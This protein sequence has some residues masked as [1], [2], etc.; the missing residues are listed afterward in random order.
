MTEAAFE[1][2]CMLKL[3]SL[4]KSY[5]P[6]KGAAGAILG[7]ADRVGCVNGRYVSLEF[8]RS[9]ADALKKTKRSALQKYNADSVQFAGGF[10][11]FVYPEN[12]RIVY[13]A[14]KGIVNGDK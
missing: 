3:A 5:W 8:K 12:W 4:P 10:S 13:A 2:K 1:K 9:F 6:P 14:I 11:A 7:N